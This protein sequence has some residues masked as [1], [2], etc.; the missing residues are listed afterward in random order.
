MSNSTLYA[1][2]EWILPAVVMVEDMHGFEGI[3]YEAN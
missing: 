3:C 2:N 1:M